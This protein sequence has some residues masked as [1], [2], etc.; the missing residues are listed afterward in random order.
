QDF[1]LNLFVTQSWHDSRLQFHGLIDA[2]HL[3]LDSKL[4][5][6]FWVPDLYFVN[7]KSSEFH[8]V[9]VPNTLLHLYRDG[10]VV[11]KMRISLTATCLMAL[12]KF[13]MDAQVCSLYMKSFGYTNQSLQF[14]WSEHNPLTSQKRLE[15]SQ[16]NLVGLDYRDCQDESDENDTFACL[17]VDLK[18]VRNVGFYM[19]QV[20]IPSVLVVVLSWVSFCLDVGS[21]PGRVSLGILTVLTITN[22]KTISVSSLPKV[23]YI[24]AIDV[25]M[26]ACLTFVFCS[27]LEF[28]VVNAFSR[29]LIPAENT[30]TVALEYEPMQ[31]NATG[32]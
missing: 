9:T 24:K 8:D 23:S 30:W 10:K 17:A 22:M 28:A 2:D 31:V 3:E 21:V 16:F 11:Y 32:T 13:P 26:A 14:Q 6:R 19:I 18:L 4:I 12:H 29:R 25:W 1:S 5:S 27:L 20:Y 7:E 15:M